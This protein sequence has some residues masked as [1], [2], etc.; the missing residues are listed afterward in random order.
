MTIKPGSKTIDTNI[1]KQIR[2]CALM[3]NEKMMKK[4]KK[5]KRTYMYRLEQMI[6]N[7][8]E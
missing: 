3:R 8:S 6:R 2:V 7:S 5:L 1:F 4:M